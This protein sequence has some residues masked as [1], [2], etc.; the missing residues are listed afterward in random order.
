MLPSH[1][2][3]TPFE[4]F[5]TDGPDH[6]P[7]VW[8]FITRARPKDG[9]ATA[10]DT[11]KLLSDYTEYHKNRAELP[12]RVHA[13]NGRSGGGKKTKL[14]GGGE[15]TKERFECP[16]RLA[17]PDVFRGVVMGGCCPG[18]VYKEPGRVREHLMRYH[19]PEFA[20]GPC[21]KVFPGSKPQAGEKKKEHDCRQGC[22]GNVNKPF[23]L[24]SETALRNVTRW[25]DI[26][27]ERGGRQ[28]MA[29]PLRRERYYFLYELA[30]DGKRHPDLIAGALAAKPS[31]DQVEAESLEAVAP[32]AVSTPATALTLPLTPTMPLAPT[33][34]PAATMPQTPSPSSTPSLPPTP[35]SL[36]ARPSVP[37]A[38]SSQGKRKASAYP[39]GRRPA[40]SDD[41]NPFSRQHEQPQPSH[42]PAQEHRPSQPPET[43]HQPSKLPQQHHTQD[44]HFFVAQYTQPLSP[45]I[46]PSN[47]EMRD[48]LL[49][50]E[51]S[52]QAL[53]FHAAR[54]P[55]SSSSQ[56]DP[57][58]AA[59]EEARSRL[60]LAFSFGDSSITAPVQYV[61]PVL[62][63]KR[64]VGTA[65]EATMYSYQGWQRQR[66][67]GRWE[68]S[69]KHWPR[70]AGGDMLPSSTP[71]DIDGTTASVGPGSVDLY[72]EAPGPADGGDGSGPQLLS[73]GNI[74]FEFESTT[75]DSDE[76]RPEELLDADVDELL[77]P[78]FEAGAEC[79]QEKVNTSAAGGDP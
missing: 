66:A 33:T 60:S 71:M 65:E 34:P 64:S 38:S 26:W 43:H 35:T 29:I 24:M 77:P 61:D 52:H 28:N 42:Q 46:P 31:P 57:E 14:S 54:R 39:E 37:A 18:K 44:S 9:S 73:D 59:E 30:I 51:R 7:A 72:P 3:T 67:P 76:E 5:C 53:H 20:C 47:Q 10:Q 40:R 41:N 70:S 15:E 11:R 69:V 2:P 6:G 23:F 58:E 1:E 19:S 56:S 8:E 27:K 17:H 22:K 74:S 36:P 75:G 62:L 13:S 63:D 12:G 68:Y 16:I 32:P 45:F 25:G 48:I 4:R 50:N 49:D 78:G 55:S 21:K 79:G